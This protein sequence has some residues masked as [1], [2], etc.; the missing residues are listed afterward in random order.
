MVPE[1]GAIHGL[2]PPAASGPAAAVLIQ[3]ERPGEPKPEERPPEP[4]PIADRIIV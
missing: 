2:A 3:A 1:E 4:G